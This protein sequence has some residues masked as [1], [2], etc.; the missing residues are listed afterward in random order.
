MSEPKPK[1]PPRPNFY[2]ELCGRI[3]ATVEEHGTAQLRV[4][5]SFAAQ[6]QRRYDGFR[7]DSA[8]ETFTLLDPHDEL[9]GWGFYLNHVVNIS[10]IDPEPEID[11]TLIGDKYRKARLEALQKQSVW[12][13]VR[14]SSK[15]QPTLA[16][17]LIRATVAPVLIGDTTERRIRN[18]LRRLERQRIPIDVIEKLRKLR[19]TEEPLGIRVAMRSFE[20]EPIPSEAG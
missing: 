8:I 2:R 9:F 1:V 15:P 17:M 11:K 6:L 20:I 18:R 5:M 19:L 16:M 4:S 7:R 3:A 12:F 14:L 13:Q 10:P